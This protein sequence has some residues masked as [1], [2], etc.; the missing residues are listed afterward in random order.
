LR[1]RMRTFTAATLR[2]LATLLRRLGLAE[3]AAAEWLL[4]LADRINR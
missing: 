3:V 4:D 2:L 1:S